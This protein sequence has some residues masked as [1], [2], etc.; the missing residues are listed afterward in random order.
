MMRSASSRLLQPEVQVILV[1]SQDNEPSCEIW[2]DPTSLMSLERD[3]SPSPRKMGGYPFGEK[4][5]Y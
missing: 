4:Q 5:G 1:I 2:V 3:S